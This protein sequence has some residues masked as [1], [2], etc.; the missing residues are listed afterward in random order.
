MNKYGHN[1][2]RSKV[3]FNIYFLYVI[4][5][6]FQRQSQQHLLSHLLFYEVTLSSQSRGSLILIPLNL[7]RLVTTTNNRVY[8]KWL[9]K[10]Q[11]LSHTGN[12]TF[13]FL[14]PRTWKSKLSCKKPDYSC[15]ATAERPH[16]GV[17]LNC[18]PCE[19]TWISNSV[20]L[21]DNS[22]SH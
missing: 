10:L 11:R 21:S 14:E 17:L 7:G 16:V 15:I 3:C 12:A 22:S 6:I 8:Q 19:S 2:L 18:R 4:D 20:E 13:T 5:C 1:S 9:S